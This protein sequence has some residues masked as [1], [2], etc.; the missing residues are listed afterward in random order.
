[1]TPF[2]APVLAVCGWSGS[3]KTTLLTAAIPR[4]AARGLAVA[5]VK[6]DAHGVEVDREGKDSDRLFRAGADVVLRGPNEQFWRRHPD[7]APSLDATL[8]DLS[9]D[10]DLILVEGHKQTPLPKL[11]LTNGDGAP[12]PS[13]VEQVLATLGME[14][15]RLAAFE[16]F[17]ESWLPAAWKARPLRGG[18]LIGGASRRMGAPK[19][20]VRFRG[21]PLA[22][23]ASDALGDGGS[24]PVV[25]LGAG[26]LPDPLSGALRIP[27]PPD[28]AGPAAGLLAAHR[29]AP[30][31]AWLVVACDHAL[32]RR[33][34]VEWLVAQRQPGVW[35]VVPRQPDGHA[36][37]TFALYEPQS[38]EVL[39]RATPGGGIRLSALLDHPATVRPVPPPDLAAAWLSADTPSALAALAE[40]AR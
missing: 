19:H 27:D 23:V 25:F 2:A 29:W 4:L 26:S 9:R 38:L 8:H 3:G 16:R 24:R 13:A 35:A 22:E 30:Q 14:N 11:W 7:R 40:Q 32:A 18:V 37:P 20:L 5:A 28:L 17:V 34:A 31:A 6:H 39:G 15:D 12:P 33:E 36:C 10:H 21:R 1:M